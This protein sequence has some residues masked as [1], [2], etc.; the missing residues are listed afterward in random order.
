MHLQGISRSSAVLSSTSLHG[1][2]HFSPQQSLWLA[3]LLQAPDLAVCEG[4]L[5]R[6]ALAFLDLAVARIVQAVRAVLL[7]PKKQNT[8]IY[9]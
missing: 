9:L 7:Q 8:T 1:P 2:Q 3:L 4:V 6:R 5:V